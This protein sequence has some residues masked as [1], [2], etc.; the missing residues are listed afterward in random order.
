MLVKRWHLGEATR[1][2]RSDVKRVI[3][4]EAVQGSFLNEQTSQGKH[5]ACLSERRVHKMLSKMADDARIQDN[6]DIPAACQ[7]APAKEP[8]P[9]GAN[10]KFRSSSPVATNLLRDQVAP[11]ERSR[12][13]GDGCRGVFPCLWP[14]SLQRV[15][16]VK[17]RPH[18]SVEEEHSARPWLLQHSVRSSGSAYV[19]TYSHQKRLPEK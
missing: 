1:C 3:T 4:E 8:K 18:E 9:N 11:G 2:P 6:H 10:G 7:S 17:G 13:A 19:E 5:W 14:T 12:S 15:P 16:H